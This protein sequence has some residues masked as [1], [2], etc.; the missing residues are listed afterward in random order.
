M[1]VAVLSGFCDSSS[2][3]R[4]G[5]RDDREL[6]SG[7]VALFIVVS[8][9]DGGAYGD[10]GTANTVQ[11]RRQEQ[12]WPDRTSVSL[13]AELPPARPG[14]VK[15]V[16]RCSII[17]QNTTE[18]KEPGGKTLERSGKTRRGD[19]SRDRRRWTDPSPHDGHGGQ[20]RSFLP[21]PDQRPSLHLFSCPWGFLF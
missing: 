4:V 3:H 9:T 19:E 21:D 15:M 10:S 17:E 8:Q 14:Y 16:L 5:R 7:G 13:L 1:M 6:A 12:G 18:G 11:N 2:A 20:D